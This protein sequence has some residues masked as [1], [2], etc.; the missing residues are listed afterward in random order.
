MPVRPIA[1]IPFELGHS[2]PHMAKH[3]ARLW[4]MF[5]R[6]YT[7]YFSE[8]AYDVGLGGT[9]TADPT[10]TEAERL[11]WRWNTSKRVD[12]LAR[13]DQEVWLCEVRPG[14]GLAAIGAVLGYTYLSELDKWSDRPI[15]MTIVT[16]H[17]D[18]DIRS[19]CEAFEIQL[20]EFPE[21]E[22]VEPVRSS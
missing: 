20:L 8:A 14:A 21:L 12:A 15:V 1:W 3:D 4:E 9:E 11:M 17:T 19:V 18:Q 6:R 13:N 16:N 2:Y 5:I 10:A 7:G 22:E